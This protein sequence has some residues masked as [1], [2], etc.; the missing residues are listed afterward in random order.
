MLN[1]SERSWIDGIVDDTESALRGVARLIE[2]ARVD[3]ATKESINFGNRFMW[4]FRDNPQVRDKGVRLSVCH[5]SLMA[6][7]ACLY[8]KDVVVIAPV[9]SKRKEEQ[10]P[11]YDSQLEE[12]FNWRN[13]RRR[14][15]SFM[16][17]QTVAA[18]SSPPVNST[19]TDTIGVSAMSSVPIHSDLVPEDPPSGNLRSISGILMEPHHLLASHGRDT[20]RRPMSMDAVPISR[21]PTASTTSLVDLRRQH[22]NGHSF[23]DSN[24]TDRRIANLT[25]EAKFRQRQADEEATNSRLPYPMSP[26]DYIYES[27]LDLEGN[28]ARPNS[29]TPISC[30]PALPQFDRELPK[31]DT[32]VNDSGTASIDKFNLPGLDSPH[33]GPLASINE[34]QLSPSQETRDPSCD[35]ADGLQL[36]MQQTGVMNAQYQHPPFSFSS[37][38]PSFASDDDLPR[39]HTNHK[40]FTTPEY[41]GLESIADLVTTVDGPSNQGE[42][43]QPDPV[44]DKGSLTQ[45]TIRSPPVSPGRVRRGGRS[46]LMFHA[47]RSDLGHYNG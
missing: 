31:L 28:D 3:K 11:P 7:I 33:A 8:S 19:A 1:N 40:T 41:E 5:Q 27:S 12:L 36:L 38:A 43:S 39:T 32:V 37:F 10:P 15:K 42:G 2:P 44:V 22:E 20:T 21:I 46:W 13:R 30:G 23:I 25:G 35:V 6:V 29:K 4:V 14:T 16:S 34:S 26:S 24:S 45:D 18:E 17:L 47:S 9:P